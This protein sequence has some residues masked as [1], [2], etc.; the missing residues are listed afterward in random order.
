MKSR[1]GG[2]AAHAVIATGTVIGPNDLAANYHRVGGRPAHP[3]IKK[4][5]GGAFVL[6]A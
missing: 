1:V 4:A 3:T 2:L 5:P 6:T